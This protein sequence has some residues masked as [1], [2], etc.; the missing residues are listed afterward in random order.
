MSSALSWLRREDER[1]VRQRRACGST[2]EARAGEP[3]DRAA[4]RRSR[5]SQN[6]RGRPDRVRSITG[7]LSQE[8]ERPS[9]RRER[10][11]RAS[12]GTRAASDPARRRHAGGVG[13]GYSTRRRAGRLHSWAW[14][15]SSGS[16]TRCARRSPRG[17][18]GRRARDERRRAGAP[19]A[20][21]P[22]GG[23]PAAR[24]RCAPRARCPAAIAVARRARSWSARTSAELARLADPARRPGEGRRRAISRARSRRGA[25]PGRPSPR[26]SAIAAR[27]GHPGLRDRRDRRGAP[28]RAGRAARRAPAT[29]RRTCRSSRARRSASSRAGPEGDPRRRRDRGGARDARRAG[30]RLAHLR[31]ARVLLGRRAA[32]RSSTGSRT[33][34]AVARVLRAPLGR[35][36]PRRGRARSLVP[37]PDPL[38]REV[39]EAAVVGGARGRR[40]PAGCAGRRS[41][42]SCSRRSRARR[43]GGR[44]PANLALLERN[45]ARRGRDRGGAR[46]RRRVESA[47]S[48]T[49][50]PARPAAHVLVADAAALGALVD[51]LRA[52]PVIALDTESNSFHVYRERVCLLQLST[53]AADFVVDPLA[54]DPAPLGEVLCDGR[55]TVLHGA[56][57]DVR[58]LRREYGWRLPRLF[59]TMAAA[60]RLGR[61]RAR[62]V[63]ARRGA[64]RGPALEDVPA[65]GLGAAAAHAAS[66]SPTPR[67]TRTTSCRST[68]CSRRSWRRAARSSEARQ[69]FDA[70]RRAS[71]RASASSTPRAGAG[72]KGAR[73]LDPA[74]PGGAAGALCS[75][76]R[77]AR[78]RPTGRR[79]RCSARQ[80]MLEIARRRP[81]TAEALGAHPGRHAVG[82]AAAGRR[83]AAALARRRR[84]RRGSARE[85]P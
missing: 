81:R 78:G 32:S 18:P 59:D 77:S 47:D 1:A 2:V 75:R 53:R 64:V 50:P 56:D 6:R 42:R 35:A 58:C 44:A 31:A 70:D 61:H 26:R 83:A 73:E 13:A 12:L 23:P 33:R 17:A 49:H 67:S 9:R 10:R 74:G 40:A 60:R 11:G 57:Y 15:A 20:R 5:P 69:E 43:R 21:Q 65:L 62:A 3:Q 80:A 63:G 66:S 37:P 79:S 34:A 39:V 14:S 72:C 8:E 71:S 46:R 22:R 48:M 19:A 76:A 24:R 85:P 16:P 55:E 45:A 38:P 68:T 7:R 30:A 82:A 54:V 28:G 29:C 36:R 84:G 51:A 27:A 52:E 41:R 4:P 25:T